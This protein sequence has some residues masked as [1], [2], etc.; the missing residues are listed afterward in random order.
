MYLVG[1]HRYWVPKQSI[2]LAPISLIRRLRV[3]GVEEHLL[4]GY[5]AVHKIDTD[6]PRKTMAWGD[7]TGL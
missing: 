2:V 4:F 1:G 3:T 5:A 6:V 7:C